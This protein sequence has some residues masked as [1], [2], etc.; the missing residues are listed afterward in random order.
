MH[1]S[2]LSPLLLHHL[3]QALHTHAPR[4]CPTLLHLLHHVLNTP[5]APYGAKHVR[6]HRFGHALV[7]L[8]SQIVKLSLIVMNI[9]MRTSPFPS[10]LD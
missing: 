10:W 2:F 7:Y 3:V 6:V 1:V 5:H 9:I 8:E 4:H